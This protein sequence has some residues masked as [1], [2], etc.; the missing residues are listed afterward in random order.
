[1]NSL[2][3]QL[4][5]LRLPRRATDLFSLLIRGD[6]KWMT[7]AVLVFIIWKFTL[8]TIMWHDRSLPPEPDDALIYSGHIYSVS[9]CPTILC[10][11]P[12]ISLSHSAGYIYF[13]YRVLW[14]ILAKIIPLEPIAFLRLTFYLGILMLVPVLM[15][16]LSRLTREKK[17][18][19]FS[20]G[21]LALFFGGG[22]YHGFFWVVPS[23]FSVLLLLLAC[24]LVLGKPTRRTYISLAL[25]IPTFVLMH[26]ISIYLLAILP[27][28]TVI[29][30]LC[31][32]RWEKNLFK[33]VCIA[34]AIGIIA[35]AP[36]L[37][38]TK[39]NVGPFS[40]EMATA[41]NRSFHSQIPSSS[42]PGVTEQIGPPAQPPTARQFMRYFV[43]S[44]SVRIFYNDYVKYLFPH[45]LALLPFVLI[46]YALL[47]YRQT[48]LLALYASALI[49]T[50]AATIHPEGFRAL[51][52]LWPITFMMY[53]FGFW[54]TF[55]LIQDTVRNRGSQRLLTAL[56]SVALAVFILLNVAYSLLFSITMMT[57][58]NFA[59]DHQFSDYLIARTAPSDP[60][61]SFSKDLLSYQMNT[62]L[63]TRPQNGLE[64]RS[65]YYTTF[66]PPADARPTPVEIF[67]T[68][69]SKIVRNPLPRSPVLP[70]TPP[71]LTPWPSPFSTIVLEKKFGDIS[72]YRDLAYPDK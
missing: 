37:V 63:I 41:V 2:T 48:K 8:I 30:S 51:I 64:G 13:S 69:M 57:K 22:V 65:K 27:L 38:I 15:V 58:D 9:H 60:I 45:P 36:L 32:R 46:V 39:N 40:K 7:V 29:L 72:I 10:E 19:S 12:G 16:L 53:G 54:F 42:T 55:R 52:I 26:P 62:E 17:L 43:L 18:I 24:A 59:I 6:N 56:T 44:P 20:L 67:F 68:T 49:F 61:A 47:R 71:P 50:L 28:F 3:K 66:T 34:V 4:Q 21:I 70:Y 23:F 11:Y 1:M 14:G 35:Y 33:N 25:V 5:H 31:S